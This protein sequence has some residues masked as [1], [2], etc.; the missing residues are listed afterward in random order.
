[1]FAIAR[2]LLSAS[3]SV[4]RTVSVAALVLM[5]APLRIASAAPPTISCGQQFAFGAIL[6]LCNGYI[7]VRATPASNTSNNACHTQA[8]GAAQAAQCTIQT[9]AGV[10]SQ[11]VRVSMT[12]PQVTAT[13]GG[14]S[15]QLNNFYVQTGAGSQTTP[16]TY[17]AALIN[18]THTFKVG[19]RLNFTNGLPT[20]AYNNST[21]TISITSIP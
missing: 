20:G 16:Y 3:K 7:R 12:A 5:S 2:R 1:M 17:A 13:H 11:N 8:S 21:I 19:A 14:G 18:P 9:T 10:A 15:V 4:P 6:P